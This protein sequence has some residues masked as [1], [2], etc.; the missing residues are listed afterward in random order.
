M[1]LQALQTL[2][3]H[4]TPAMTARYAHLSPT[5]LRG[6]IERTTGTM[7]PSFSTKSAHD[8]AETR[9]SGDEP[10]EVRERTGA[11]GGS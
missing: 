1:S 10:S 9:A 7:A 5:F 4:A 8:A 11:G 2:L 6:E 3:G